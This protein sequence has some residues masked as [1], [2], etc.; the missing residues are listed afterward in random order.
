MK[1]GD[2]IAADN[3]HEAMAGSSDPCK[4]YFPYR[5]VNVFL[6]N[7]TPASVEI[8]FFQIK[9]TSGAV[10]PG[11]SEDTGVV[12]GAVNGAAHTT[13]NFDPCYAGGYKRPIQGTFFDGSVKLVYG[14]KEYDVD[15]SAFAADPPGNYY[16]SA[17]WELTVG[18]GAK[19]VDGPAR[20]VAR[21]IKR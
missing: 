5:T 9:D 13:I 3:P 4:D 20:F 2:S 6:E 14:G 17:G 11:F 8:W 1:L 21:P 15:L 10:P 12:V 18:G 16:G 7:N 19:G